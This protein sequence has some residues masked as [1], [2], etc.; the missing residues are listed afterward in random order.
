MEKNKNTK[1][2]IVAGA[3]GEIGTAY[4]QKIAE[5]GW[6][7]IIAVVRNRNLEG[8][9][10][11]CV[12]QIKC[13]LDD[14][15]DVQKKF[16]A[17]D[18]GN[19]NEV[20]YL[21][22]IGVDKFQSR[23]FPKI[24]KLQTIDPDVYDANV[25]SFKYVLKYLGTR[26]RQINSTQG[27]KI[28]MRIAAVLGVADKYAPFVIEDFCEAK[29]IVREYMRTYVERHPGW[30]SALGINITSTITKSAV[31]IRPHADTTY[32]L[33]PQEVAD[34]SCDAIMDGEHKDYRE[35]DII[36]FSPDYFE[37]YYEDNDALY[38]KWSRETGCT[39]NTA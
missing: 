39:E 13:Y 17:I 36:K 2:V 20:I 14:E 38:T 32:W 4:V 8:V 29:F 9:T 22:S 27:H 37:S 7:D 35:I 30:I 12:R 23:N 15:R 33:T 31:E 28:H 18:L 6:A 24:T 34:R 10:H 16:D 5:S 19:Y 11:D 3:A 1:L 26:I 21:H 25:N